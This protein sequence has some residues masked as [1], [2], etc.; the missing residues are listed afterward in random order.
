MVPANVRGERFVADAVSVLVCAMINIVA[1]G[2]PELTYLWLN[3]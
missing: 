2:A 1:V 3:W